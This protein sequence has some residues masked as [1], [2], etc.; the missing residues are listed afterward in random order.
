MSSMPISSNAFFIPQLQGMPRMV[1]LSSMYKSQ[2]LMSEIHK[3]N[4]TISARWL[5]SSR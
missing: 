3:W 5:F 2:R 1:F 4:E